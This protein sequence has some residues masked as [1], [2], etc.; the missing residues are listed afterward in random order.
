M[1]DRQTKPRIALVGDFDPTVTAHQAIQRSFA[2]ADSAVE[3]AWLATESIVAGDPAPLESFSG[4]W[5]VPASPYRNTAGA[6]WAIRFA[7]ERGRPFLGTCGGFQHALL[8]YAHNVLGLAHADH[9]ETNPA[10][11]LPLLVRLQCSLVEASQRIIVTLP[12]TFRDAYGADSGEEGF[13]CNY[14]LNPR[15]EELFKSGQ[16]QISARSADGEARGIQLVGHPFFLG[17][18][19]QPERRAFGGTLHPLVRAFFD[20]SVKPKPPST[21]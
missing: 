20:A 1:Q 2:I 11:E 7:R 12:G 9:A 15:F 19:F 16:L 8:E 10:A 6:L 14:G 21:V 18:L 4:F 13:R 17:T 3:P 5:C